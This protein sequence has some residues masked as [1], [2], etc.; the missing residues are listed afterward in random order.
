[1]TQISQDTCNLNASELT[2]LLPQFE[3]ELHGLIDSTQIRARERV[4]AGHRHP[5][6][7][8]ADGQ[9]AGR[10]QRGR[11]WQSPLGAALY[12]TVIWP[13]G[14]RLAKLS[15]LSLVAGLSLRACLAHWQIDAQ[16]K[17]PNDVWVNE[18]KLAG[19]LV[20]A[21]ADPAGS[22]LLI[23][24]GLNI[25]LPAPAA[26]AIDQ[27]WIDLSLLL[28]RPP[29]RSALLVDLLRQLHGDLCRFEQFGLSAFIDEWASADALNNRAIW[30]N[31]AEQSEA[32]LALGI[33][34]LGR[35]KV[36]V[37]GQIR[38]LSAGDVRIRLQSAPL[39]DSPLPRHRGDQ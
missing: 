6:V 31:S 7:V 15:G 11:Q 13:S 17:W 23:G 36:E 16:L 25:C 12:L 22:T 8:L 10:G 20:E 29:P 35:L 14:R 18:R 5:A 1:M 4:L 26:A 39:G 24:I 19:I 9:L 37:G 33:D 30:I 2:Q 32:G 28:D 34:E 3:L 27:D 21:L 38:F